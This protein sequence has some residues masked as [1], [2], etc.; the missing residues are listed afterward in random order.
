MA[1]SLDEYQNAA[2]RTALYPGQG[3]FIGLAYA[4]MGLNGE[5]GETGEQVKKIWR[6]EAA[7][8]QQICQEAVVEAGRGLRSMLSY[9]IVLERL[10]R[11]IGGAFEVEITEERREKILKELGDTLWYAAQVC[12]ELGV[13]MADVAQGNINKLAL[14]QS[15]NKLHGEGSDR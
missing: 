14:R 13:S 3:T 6:D 7:D 1:L 11:R 5:A 12:T 15:A 8:I 9:E 4:I 10:E 2:T